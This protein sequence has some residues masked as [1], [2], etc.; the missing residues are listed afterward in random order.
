MKHESIPTDSF[1]SA[2]VSLFPT[3][4]PATSA[5]FPR[6]SSSTWCPFTRPRRSSG[7]RTS[8]RQ[9]TTRAKVRLHRA[10]HSQDLSVWF[11]ASAHW[12]KVSKLSHPLIQVFFELYDCPVT[13]GDGHFGFLACAVSS[14]TGRSSQAAWLCPS[15]TSSFWPSTTTCWGTS[16]SFAWSPP[17]RSGRT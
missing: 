10:V 3:R 4:F 7:T 14:F 15:W 8:C 2:S 6:L 12:I 9:S 13:I 5:E 11:R 16:T 1:S 17:T